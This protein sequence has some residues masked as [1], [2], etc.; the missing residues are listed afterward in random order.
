MPATALAELLDSQLRKMIAG[1]E[2]FN[3]IGNI[4]IPL[5]LPGQ[6]LAVLVSFPLIWTISWIVK[7][8]RKQPGELSLL[9]RLAP[10][11]GALTG[12]AAFLFALL[13]LVQTGV[14]LMGA[15]EMQSLVGVSRSFIWI[16]TLPWAIAA[17]V[18]AMTVF[19]V[20]SWTRAFWGLP[21]RIYYS[22]T[23]LAAVLFTILLALEG[24]FAVIF[25]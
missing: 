16:Y 19:T 8:I 17:L 7:R 3:I 15:G 4:L 12:A 9:P 25:S 18:I 6:L 2:T 22:L 21:R 5:I 23:S 13:V 14:Q 24:I 11:I 1:G 20:I 10:W